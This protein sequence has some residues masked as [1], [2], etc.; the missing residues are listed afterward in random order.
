MCI[1]QIMSAAGR[2]SELTRSLLAFGRKQIINPK[3][4][5][6]DD[7]VINLSKLLTR[8]IG[9]DIE[10]S[11]SLAGGNLTVMADSGQIDQV[12]INLVTNARDAMPLG[13]SFTSG[14]SGSSSTKK[15]H[16]GTIWKGWCLCR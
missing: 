6:I 9:E 8:L 5:F 1:G 4:L 11:T 2:A 13:G 7:I 16:N 3:P 14:P 12:L 10:F 15:Q